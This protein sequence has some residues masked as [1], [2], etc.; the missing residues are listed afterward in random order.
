MRTITTP[1][2]RKDTRSVDALRT[3]MD[4]V[5]RHPLLTR[6]E[7]VALGKAITAA[8]D[9]ADT[10]ARDDLSPTARAHLRR[11]IVSG[12]DATRRFIEANLRLVVSIASGSNGPGITQADLIQDGNLGLMRAV[13]RYDWRKGFKFSTYATWW[14]RQAITRGL[15]DQIHTIHIPAYIHYRA[16]RVER[17][18]DRLIG[19]LGRVP[20]REELGRSCGL[21]GPE[22][23][24]VGGLPGVVA[25]LDTAHGT[26]DVS[27]H[28]LLSVTSEGPER[29]V[30]ERVLA[31]ELLGAL[32][33]LGDRERLILIN[34]FGLAGTEARTLT[35]IA[36][37][38]GLTRE[39][40]RQIEQRALHKLADPAQR[41]GKRLRQAAAT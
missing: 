21:T 13:A 17:T 14:I 3:Y 8:A 6:A 2:G 40:I 35:A 28:D 12:D 23:I 24:A 26:T 37:E 25:S 10:L 1:R 11:V 15:I 7:E 41:A 19:E 16:R 5:G 31:A 32:D 4:E 29:I 39:R 22:M 9:A 18:T 20:S 27:F 30:G 34:R 36:G 33:H 38:V